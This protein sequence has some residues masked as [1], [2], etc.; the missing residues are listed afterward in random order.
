MHERICSKIQTA[1]RRQLR[2]ARRRDKGQAEG[3]LHSWHRNWRAKH[4]EFREAVYAARAVST[5]QPAG[6]PLPG[7][8]APPDCLGE[9]R[10]A[11]TG[12]ACGGGTIALRPRS[13]RFVDQASGVVGLSNDTPLSRPLKSQSSAPGRVSEPTVR[14][15]SAS[16]APKGTGSE[17]HA[18]HYSSTSSMYGAFAREQGGIKRVGSAGGGRVQGGGGIPIARAGKASAPYT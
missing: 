15:S 10:L 2:S 9:R 18:G 6:S 5:R 17:R 11:P 3:A 12:R 13:G 4:Q 7:R 14:F 1:P 8:L 16:A